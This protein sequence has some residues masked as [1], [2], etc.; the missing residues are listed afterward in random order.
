VDGTYSMPFDIGGWHLFDG[1]SGSINLKRELQMQAQ[2]PSLRTTPK[3]CNL[4]GFE[5]LNT[6]RQRLVRRA[7]RLIRPQGRLTLVTS[8]NATVQNEFAKYLNPSQN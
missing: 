6:L 4:W 8:G 7:G 2:G 1:C 5:T 3:R